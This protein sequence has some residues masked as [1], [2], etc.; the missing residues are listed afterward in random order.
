MIFE[1]KST[2]Y[3][4]NILKL[5]IYFKGGEEKQ[6]DTLYELAK[7]ARDR[8]KEMRKELTENII[9]K[10]TDI[11]FFCFYISFL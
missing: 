5:E 10:N 4:W 2:D 8:G 6:M 11:I 1:N 9:E 3:I 7:R